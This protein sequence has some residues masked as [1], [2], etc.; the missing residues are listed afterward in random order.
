[1]KS[2]YSLLEAIIYT[3]KIC[4]GHR[5]FNTYISSI[6]WAFRFYYA[7]SQLVQ[8]VLRIQH[9]ASVGLKRFGEPFEDQLRFTKNSHTRRFAI[10]VSFRRKLLTLR[11][12]SHGRSI[13]FYFAEVSARTSSDTAST[14]VVY[15]LRIQFF[16]L[17]TVLRTQ[18]I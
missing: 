17:V 6:W 11:Q 5:I 2:K 12:L 1:M 16:V 9:D 3:S 4:I 10:T 7:T 13:Y 14:C 8:A 15:S 18:F